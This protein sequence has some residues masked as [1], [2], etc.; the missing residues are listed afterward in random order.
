MLTKVLD[1]LMIS[2]TELHDSFPEAKFYIGFRTPFR[3]DRNKNGGGILL[4][5]QKKINAF[6]SQIMYF[7][8]ILTLSPLR[9]R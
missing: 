9:Q 7:L 2:E 8:A 6:H 4:Y 3:L 5:V 1:I